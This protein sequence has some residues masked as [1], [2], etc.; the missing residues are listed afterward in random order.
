MIN[1]ERLQIYLDTL[2]R[3]TDA[4][5]GA[6]FLSDQEIRT[7]PLVLRGMKY[8]MIVIA[9][10][11]A[12]ICQHILAREHKVA[13][14]GFSETLSKAAAFGILE[15]ELYKRLAPFLRFRN[16]LVHGYWKVDDTLL[17][18]NLRSGIGDFSHFAE[19]IKRRFAADS[20]VK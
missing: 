2:A 18:N 8:S 15:D 12:E 13:V 14:S 7:M 5:Q 6:L 10:V 1:R 11:M 4:L 17:L 3:E 16:L 20:P 9:E 19:T